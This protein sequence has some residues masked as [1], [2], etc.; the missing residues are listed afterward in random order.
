MI[1]E[2][3]PNRCFIVLSDADDHKSDHKRIVFGQLKKDSVR[4]SSR[5]MTTNLTTKKNRYFCRF[6]GK[7]ICFH[8]FLT[9]F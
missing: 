6:L 8:I 3:P 9:R 4:L 2:S 7:N 1:C 5:W